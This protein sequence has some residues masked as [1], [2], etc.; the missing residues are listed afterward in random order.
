VLQDSPPQRVDQRQLDAC[1]QMAGRLADRFHVPR[2]AGI[3]AAER[4]ERRAGSPYP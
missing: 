3:G 2:V 1:I 4:T